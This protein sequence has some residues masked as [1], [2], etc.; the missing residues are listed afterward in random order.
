M[1]GA[2]N[3]RL[4]KFKNRVIDADVS[5]EI[6]DLEH[7]NDV[8]LTRTYE[9]AKAMSKEE[10]IVIVAAAVEKYPFETY[11]TLALHAQREKE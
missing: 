5:K 1:S 9:M 11:R 3:Y 10:L 6:V 8:D 7:I 2:I 4:M